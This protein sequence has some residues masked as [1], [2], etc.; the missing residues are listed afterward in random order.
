MSAEISETGD[1]IGVGG[2]RDASVISRTKARRGCQSGDTGRETS[3]PRLRLVWSGPGQSRETAAAGESQPARRPVVTGRPARPEVPA[4]PQVPTRR[5]VAARPQ[6]PARRQVAT[7]QGAARRPVPAPRPAVLRLTRR[8]RVV[9]TV[10]MTLAAVAT[11]TVLRTTVA[12]GAPASGPGAPGGSPYSG[13]TQ[14][15]VRPG[16]TVWSLAATAEPSANPWTVVQEIMEVNALN[17]PQI[18]AGQTLWV[19]RP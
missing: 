6:V 3:Q 12:G 4:R 7:R 18:Q 8:G 1:L 17:G 10:A 13:M 5:Q 11:V 2:A 15:V 9:V 14:V 16:Q 19:P